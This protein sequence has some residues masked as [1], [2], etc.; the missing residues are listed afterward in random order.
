MFISF[1][2]P[3]FALFYEGKAEIKREEEKER[4]S[5]R[6]RLRDRWIN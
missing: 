6:E 2:F 4:E 5:E 1:E 3:W